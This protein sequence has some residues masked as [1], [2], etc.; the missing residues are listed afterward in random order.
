MRVGRIP[1]I[2]CYPGLRR[3]RSRHRAAGRR[4]GRRRSD[5]R[6]TRRWPRARS[7][8]A[9]SRRSS[10]RAIATQYLLLPDLAISCDG[11]VRSVV[12]FSKRPAP[13]LGG[14]RVLREPQLD[15]QRRAARA[16]VRERLAMRSR[17]SCPA[18]R[19]SATSRGSAKR[20][21]T[22]VSSSATRRSPARAPGRR[23]H[24]GR[25][26]RY[27]FV[28]DLGAEWKRWTGLPFVFAVWVAQRT[29]PVADALA[30]HAA[31]IASR[32]WGLAAPR[33][34]AAQAR[35]ATRRRRRSVPRVPRRVSTTAC[36]IRTSPD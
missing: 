19:S 32:D 11:P 21:T 33:P 27:P 9:W 25:Q 35:S 5:G 26:A 15:D 3:D 23:A 36:R 4:A 24:P 14:R 30:V 31:L 6:S 28:Y 8:S 17:S 20:S 1:Y 10:T 2:N 16:A 34:L 18:T 29:T 22:R 13:E 12:L 7:T